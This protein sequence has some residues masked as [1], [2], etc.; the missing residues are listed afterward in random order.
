[1][2][3]P[4][5]NR[6]PYATGGARL[7]CI[8]EDEGPFWPVVASRSEVNRGDWPLLRELI[9][10]FGVATQNDRSRSHRE[11]SYL[12]VTPPSH[13]CQNRRTSVKINEYENR[14]SQGR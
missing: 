7:W 5:A 2:K 8:A 6:R 13:L 9:T 14:K 12:L 3:M 4:K 10:G 11:A 1:M